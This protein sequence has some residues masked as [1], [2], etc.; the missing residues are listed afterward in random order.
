MS[1]ALG[2]RRLLSRHVLGVRPTYR[3]DAPRR[4][5]YKFLRTAR[6]HGCTT[7]GG[8]GPGTACARQPG[9]HAAGG[10]RVCHTHYGDVVRAVRQLPSAAERGARWCG[11][12]RGPRSGIVL[13]GGRGC[14]G[15]EGQSSALRRSFKLEGFVC[16]TV[17]RL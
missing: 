12:G 10:S 6:I 14:T 7:I 13:E 17:L 2:T 1:G 15:V 9:A 8:V 5:S 3:A 11:R 16:I 4:M